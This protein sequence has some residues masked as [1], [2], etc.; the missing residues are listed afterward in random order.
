MYIHTIINAIKNKIYFLIIFLF[1]LIISCKKE[2]NITTANT[3]ELLSAKKGSNAG[4]Y[5]EQGRY[6]ILRGANYNVL[7]DYWQANTTVATQK[8]FEEKEVVCRGCGNPDVYT[9]CKCFYCKRIYRG[10][11]N[12]APRNY[13]SEIKAMEELARLRVP[14]V[15][16]GGRFIDD[17][18]PEEK[19]LL[20]PYYEN[21]FDP[22]KC[23]CH[24]SNG[25]S[26]MCN[27]TL[28]GPKITC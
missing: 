5:D 19:Q 15:P 16:I 24:P 18:L 6:I 14:W 11:G 1:S 17:E 13:E 7:G 22:S 10:Q 27:C 23:G 9:N 28:A 3:L 4:I 21:G 8:Q 26:G 12:P 25:G 2:Q 20:I